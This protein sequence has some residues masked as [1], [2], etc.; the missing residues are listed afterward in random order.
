MPYIIQHAHGP[1][2]LLVG[3]R[4]WGD[5]PEIDFGAITSCITLVEQ[6]PDTA[7][8]IRAIHLS[9]FSGDG[10]PIYDPD[11]NVVTQIDGIMQGTGN[12]R[13]CLGRIDFWQAN[14]SAEVRN[15][16]TSLMQRL[17]IETWVQTPNVPLRVRWNQ[18][19]I[20]Y[21]QGG[22]WVSIPYT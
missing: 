18:D 9:I 21:T 7:N 19:T 13:A 5:A 1:V 12:F 6:A 2:P 20:Q 4:F 17:G 22:G 3:E 11:S 14:Q 15:F 10:T 16:F 8:S